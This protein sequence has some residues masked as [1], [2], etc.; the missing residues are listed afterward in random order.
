M[1]K[2]AVYAALALAATLIGGVSNSPAATAAPT[3]A[4]APQAADAS[5]AARA[6]ALDGFKRHLAEEVARRLGDRRLRDA[7]IHELAGDGEADLAALLGSVPG[8]QDLAAYARDANSQ[9]LKLKGIEA[10][11]ALLQIRIDPQS[12][13]RI[14][15]GGTLV[16]A[17]PSGDEKTVRTVVA[18]GSNGRTQELDAFRAPQRP[19][20]IVGLDEHKSAE[21]AQQTIR[22]YLTE[23]GIGGT[24][25]SAAD[26]PQT[27]NSLATRPVSTV[28]RIVNRD[29]HEPWYKGGPEIYA[30]VAG[31]GLD[32]KARVDQVEMPYITKE[33]TVYS[34]GQSLIEWSNFSWT[35]VD[36]VFMEHDDNSD[37]SGLIR[38]VVDGVLTVAGYE[39]Y[40]P[41]AD[42]IVAALPS[43][44][45]KDDD[46]WVDSCYNINRQTTDVHCAAIPSG[47]SLVLAFHWL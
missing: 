9:I 14:S 30:W 35:S 46:D 41:V 16:M 7:L 21:L 27:S 15:A 13:E 3:P 19:V 20:L 23:A 6:D 34:P 32:G 36:V 22:R 42:K 4:P 18:Y 47:M 5:A 45:T 31:A 10:E 24:D 43:G 44:W 37:L 40:V 33:G 29:D 2:T 25:R 38:A 12:V 11:G 28:F 17:T 8:T 39:K 26:E 1:K